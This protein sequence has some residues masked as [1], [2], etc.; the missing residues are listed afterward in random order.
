MHVRTATIQDLSQLAALFDQYR[1]FYK[2]QTDIGGA[3]AFLEKRINQQDSVIFVMEEN[4]MLVGFTQ[5]YPSF[6]SVGMKP[7]WI[8]NDLFVKESFRGKGVAAQL[9]H[10]AV[11]YSRETGRRK[12]VLST[13]YD[14]E[15][16][17][18]LYERLGFTRAE[19][20][21]YELRTL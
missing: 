7:I 19:F 14:N 4:E 16:A 20:Y 13:A 15:T 11:N 17:Q 8:L 2:Q 12:I 9:I 10:Q 5:L 1:I 18:R 3:Y 6:S 21:N